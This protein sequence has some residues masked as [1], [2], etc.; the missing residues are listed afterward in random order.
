MI[1]YTVHRPDGSSADFKEIS[2]IEKIKV[3]FDL[4]GKTFEDREAAEL[5]Q[6]RLMEMNTV[7]DPVAFQIAEKEVILTENYGPF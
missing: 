4:D 6:A 5:E 2:K 7:A 3:T 1:K